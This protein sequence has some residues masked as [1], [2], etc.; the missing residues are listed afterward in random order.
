[1]EIVTGYLGNEGCYLFQWRSAATNLYW[2]DFINASSLTD[3]KS[4]DAEF[5]K[6][7]WKV[8]GKVLET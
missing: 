4:S 3:K 6:D 1:M 5:K 7:E 2:I 8:P